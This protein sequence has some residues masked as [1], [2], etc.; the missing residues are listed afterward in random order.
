LVGEATKLPV[1]R[2]S[3]DVAWTQHVT[4]NVPSKADLAS[5]LARVLRPGGRLAMFEVLAGSGAPHLPTPWA[6]TPS[7]SFLASES[8]LKAELGRAGF[9]VGIF[10]DVTELS[11]EWAERAW[12]RIRSG[13]GRAAAVQLL[14]GSRAPEMVSNMWRNL[15][16]G[17]IRTI[18]LVA[19]LAADPS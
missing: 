5:E 14:M 18:E 11:G 16:E 7:Q 10:K 6:T 8:E 2:G 17:R 4:M 12:E 15:R 9:T 19:A 1:R 3:F 13:D